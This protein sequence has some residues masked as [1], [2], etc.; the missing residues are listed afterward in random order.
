MAKILHTLLWYL[1]KKLG[2][3]LVLYENKHFYYTKIEAY[4]PREII[5][6]F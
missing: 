6:Y 1:A 5:V 3:G 2:Y 4:M